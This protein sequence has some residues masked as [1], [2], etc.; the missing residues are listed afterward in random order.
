MADVLLIQPPNIQGALFNLPG[1]EIPLSLLYISAYLKKSGYD[2]EVLDLSLERNYVG[3]LRR[4]LYKSPP[5]IVGISSY[6]TNVGVAAAIARRVKRRWPNT[7]AVLGGFHASALPKETL[8]EFPVFDCLVFGEGEKTL[9]EIFRAMQKSRD[10]ESIEGLAYR[11]GGRVRVNAGRELIGDLDALP[12]PDRDAVRVERYVPDPGN[13]ASLPTTGILFSRGCPM[14]CAFCSKSVF[15]D[16]IRYRSVDSFLAEVD[17]CRQKYGIKD[18]RFFDEG[19]T[20]QKKNMRGLC[21]GILEKDLKITWNCFSRVDTVDDNLLRLM[22]RAGCYHVIYGVESAISETQ[23]RINKPIDLHRAAEVC[24]MTRATGMECKVNFILGFPWEGEAEAEENIRFA[25]S[26]DADLATFNLF[27]PLPG[28][29]LYKQLKAEGALFNR[30]WEDYFTT[31]D[32]LLFASD[33]S[34]KRWRKI[35][36]NAW[37]RF[38]FRPRIVLGRMRRLMRNP[39]HETRTGLVGLSVLLRNLFR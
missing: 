32:S 34:P 35:L 17:L 20:L 9:V 30:P 21:E 22:A 10:F 33:V 4:A 19:P 38:Y 6:T 2:C 24:R 8:E 3:V 1:T 28:S 23:K 25:L 18:F 7:P 39:L 14:K 29:A 37:L 15:A 11:Q 27:K 12:F 26:L 31:G 16:T 36:K 13:Y 5:G